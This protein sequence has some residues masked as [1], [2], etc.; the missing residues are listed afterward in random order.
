MP[1]INCPDCGKS[2]SDKA[3]Y[4]IHCGCPLPTTI[5][6]DSATPNPLVEQSNNTYPLSNPRPL[7]HNR[8]FLL[9][10]LAIVA[11]ILICGIY[12]YTSFLIP[13]NNYDNAVI[14]LNAG[15]YESAYEEF[16]K[17]GDYKDCETL[18]KECI[19]EEAVTL[20]ESGNYE[21]AHSKLQII[22]DYKDSQSLSEQC[23]Y[24]TYLLNAIVD[25]NNYLKNPTSL[26]IK[27]VTF[28]E[29]TKE[30][31]NE[32]GVNL[33]AWLEENKYDGYPYITIKYS[34]ENGFGGNNVGYA[35]FI[36]TDGE[37][38]YWGACPSLDYDTLDTY[39]EQSACI[40][41]GQITAC[42]N[43][44]GEISL[45]RINTLLSSNL[46]SSVPLLD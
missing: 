38:S 13:Q 35:C 23:K 11:L 33:A 22:A 5:Q 40:L 19:Y 15:N 27:E 44:V 8:T 6:G 24:E 42:C 43:T 20:L 39:E 41:I 29:G 30:G 9:S 32:T 45:D 2:I 18:S 16:Q 21:S 28:Y 17:L 26:Q 36:C 14:L 34:A 25:F 46:Y 3:S 31:L 7:N 4:C 1:L 37:Y 12:L 10:I